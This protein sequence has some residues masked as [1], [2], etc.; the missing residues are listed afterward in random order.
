M[1]HISEI[2]KE[3]KDRYDWY[4]EDKMSFLHFS[5]GLFSWGILVGFIVGKF[6]F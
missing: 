1:K 4:H 2:M 3:H 6:I 5:A